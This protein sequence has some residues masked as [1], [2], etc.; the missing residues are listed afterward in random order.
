MKAQGFCSVVVWY[1][2]DLPCEG[3]QG[4]DVR[5]Y[6]PREEHQNVTRHVGSNATFYIV[7]EEDGLAGSFGETYIQVTQY[8]IPFTLNET[9]IIIMWMK[10][11]QVVAAD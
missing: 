2:P 8:F 9:V 6:H 5:L 11:L 1:S 7:K 10:G 3:I 4:Y